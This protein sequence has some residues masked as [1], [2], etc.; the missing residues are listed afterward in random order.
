MKKILAAALT[1]IAIFA[2]TIPRCAQAQRLETTDLRTGTA[3]TNGVAAGVVVTNTTAAVST[4]KADSTGT[5]GITLRGYF[6]GAGASNVVVVFRRIGAGSQIESANFCTWTT[7]LNGTSTNVALTNITVGAAHGL[8]PYTITHTHTGT[9]TCLGLS[10][11]IHQ[12]P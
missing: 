8:L 2:V 3:L 6:S 5:V 1:A 4:L 11:A 9:F 12:V 7:P 10:G